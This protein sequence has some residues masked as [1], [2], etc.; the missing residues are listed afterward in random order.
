MRS[1]LKRSDTLAYLHTVSPSALM[2]ANSMNDRISAHYVEIASKY[3]ELMY[4]EFKKIQHEIIDER[5]KMSRE[6][7]LTK[8]AHPSY[9]YV[10]AKNETE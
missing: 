3:A 8:Y 6:E 2:P 4:E 7:R 9:K 1:S 5:N 10:A